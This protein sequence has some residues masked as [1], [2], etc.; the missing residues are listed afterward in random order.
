MVTQSFK[1]RLTDKN[2]RVNTVC[3]TNK[4]C[5]YS[6]TPIVAMPFLGSGGIE[7]SHSCKWAKLI[8]WHA[9]PHIQQ[10]TQQRNKGYYPNLHGWD[11][12]I[13]PSPVFACQES[14]LAVHSE[15]PFMVS[16]LT[17]GNSGHLKIGG[18]WTPV[19]EAFSYGIRHFSLWFNKIWPYVSLNLNEIC[20]IPY[21]NASRTGDRN[22]PNV[23]QIKSVAKTD[24]LDLAQVPFVFSTIKG[25]T[26]IKLFTSPQ[27]FCSV[28]LVPFY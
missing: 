16:N 8:Q 2:R 26:K 3:R 24:L 7:K 13:P 19:R 22:L 17:A 4:L 11:F 21:E 9:L 6:N 15:N 5:C 28:H 20:R 23:T 1:M 14:T 27:T 10:S 25:N 18:L 12:S